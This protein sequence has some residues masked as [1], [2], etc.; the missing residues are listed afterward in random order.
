EFQ[1]FCRQAGIGNYVLSFKVETEKSKL[2][3]FRKRTVLEDQEFVRH[4]Q[5][6][7]HEKQ[8]K[9]AEEKSAK[10]NLTIGYPIKDEPVKM[11]TI[12]EEERI[13]S[14][15]GFVYLHEFRELRSG[16]SLLILTVTDYA[17]SVETKMFADNDDD[18]HLFDSSRQKIGI[19]ARGNLQTDQFS[20]V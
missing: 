14:V 4:A 6:Q 15:Q 16:L 3:D 12:F 19:R 18:A 7:Q 20:G 13:L 17:N 2:D 9:Q 8:T 1:D 10:E 11:E 5:K